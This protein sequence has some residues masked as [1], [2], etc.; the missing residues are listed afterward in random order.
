MTV[1]TRAA[2]L[3]SMPLMATKCIARPGSI[4]DSDRPAVLPCVPAS[5]TVFADAPI[6]AGL[7]GADG[8]G[9]G[10]EAPTEEGSLDARHRS[11]TIEGRSVGSVVVRGVR[12]PELTDL[13]R[14]ETNGRMSAVFSTVASRVNRARTPAGTRARSQAV[15]G[16]SPPRGHAYSPRVVPPGT[17]RP[18]PGASVRRTRRL[19]PATPNLLG[20]F[21]R[22]VRRRELDD[23]DFGKVVHAIGAHGLDTPEDQRLNERQVPHAD[24]SRSFP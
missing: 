20:G 15:A 21:V 22:L 14:A 2:V 9:Q 11:R 24:Q 18:L 13:E 3:R 8:A 1:T 23:S 6:D 19:Q 16:P 4:R 12:G 5:A 7:S 10:R 17:A